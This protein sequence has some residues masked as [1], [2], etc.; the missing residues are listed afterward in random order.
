ME[1]L[2]W[3]LAEVVDCPALDQT[4]Q[5]DIFKQAAINYLFRVTRQQFGTYTEVIR[6]CRDTVQ[7]RHVALWSWSWNNL[8]L[9]D[10]HWYALWCGC[11]ELGCQEC[12]CSLDTAHSL[13]LPDPVVSVDKVLL[14]GQEFTDYRLAGPQGNVLVRTDG[15]NWPAT[16]DRLKPA[17]MQD[18]FEV[19][20]TRGTPVPAGGKLAAAL[21][22]CEL[23]KA[24]TQDNTCK[25]PRRVQTIA[26]QGVT[27][28]F[29]DTFEGLGEGQT[30]IWEI[31]SWVASVNRPT[32][33]AGV[34]S[35]D[36]CR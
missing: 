28:G 23:A 22:A 17:S 27:V 12:E 34:R 8:L 30:G 13:H 2:T 7:E 15:Q 24:V 1:N 25:L 6:P 36:V 18:T 9:G 33:Q 10:G 14:D 3:P 11:E 20:Y 29:V 4:P 31:D 32:P 16:Q 26:R 35:V 19:T 5:Q 21:L